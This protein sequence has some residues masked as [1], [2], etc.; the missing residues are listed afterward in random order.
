MRGYAGGAEGAERIRFTNALS[1]QMW[2]ARSI[3]KSSSSSVYS[4]EQRDAIYWLIVE[5]RSLLFLSL[6]ESDSSSDGRHPDESMR[7]RS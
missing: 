2:L 6:V 3:V 1:L 5:W 4:L 7:G